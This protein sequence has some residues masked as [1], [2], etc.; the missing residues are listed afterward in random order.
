MFIATV[1]VL[2]HT[3]TLTLEM[4]LENGVFDRQ[5]YSVPFS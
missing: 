3:K 2:P 1:T 5:L 4:T